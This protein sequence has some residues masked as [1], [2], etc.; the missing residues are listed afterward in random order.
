MTLTLINRLTPTGSALLAHTL[1]NPRSLEEWYLFN[2]NKL[3]A[4]HNSYF[5]VCFFLIQR[6]LSRILTLLSSKNDKAK[7]SNYSHTPEAKFY[8]NSSY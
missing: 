4:I 8:L 7:K 6:S 1:Q 2:E 3:E 5:E